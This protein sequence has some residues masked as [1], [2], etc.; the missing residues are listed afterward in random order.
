[1][2]A[3]SPPANAYQRLRG[4]IAFLVRVF[5]RRLEVVGLENVPAD[6]GGLLV[7]WHP[8]GLV[9]PTLILSAFPKTIVFGARHGLFKI[10]LLGRFM[11]AIGTVPIYRRQDLPGGNVE[12]QRRKNDA[13]MDLLADS[14][15]RGSFSAL[16]PEGITHDTPFLQEL[17]TGAARLYY[18]ARTRTPDGQAPPVVIPVG[19]HY[20]HKRV[21]RSCALVVFHPPIELRP[22]LDVSP[23]PDA[24]P[25]AVRELARELTEDMERELRAVILE[26][27]SWQVH[28]LLHRARKLIRAERAHRAAATLEEATLDEKVVGF[29]RIWTGY[30]ELLRIR[31]ALVAK[32]RRRI[33]RYDGHLRSLGIEDEELDQPPAVFG[34]RVGLLLVV[35]AVAVFVVLPPLL[36]VGVMV[37]LPPALLLSAAASLLVKKQSAASFKLGGG[38]VLFPLTWAIWAWLAMTQAVRFIPG[39]PSSPWLAAGWM[40]ALS[41]LGGVVMV[42]YLGWAS[43]T[44]HAI[45]VRL[46]RSQ[47]ARAFKRLKKE[48]AR[49][50]DDLLAMTAGI[51]LPG[52]VHPDGR[53]SR[54]HTGEAPS[55]AG[56]EHSSAP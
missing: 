54:T 50:C 36:V 51:Q 10:P 3:T 6:R 48:R 39:M 22:E 27:E 1:M 14:I 49:M 41:V 53:I 45:R 44:L 47:R 21:F 24:E 32:L 52:V 28:R 16:F 38:I 29:M 13:S 43:A 25:E 19:I 9:D 11:K 34:R 35:Q 8:N 2:I 18:R 33:E 31:P 5:F 12:D 4:V 37:N 26:T 40:I 23:A 7:A 55:S 56:V 15:A 30:R 17:K 42:A 46:T 20:D